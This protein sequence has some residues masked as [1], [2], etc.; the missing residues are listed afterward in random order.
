MANIFN[1]IKNYGKVKAE[2]A[3]EGAV[4]F[5]AS[6]DANGVSEAAIKQK[7]DEHNEM[8]KQLVDAQHSFK[9]E[10]Q[11]FDDIYQL[12]N[13]KVAAAERAQADLDKDP[14][15]ADAQTALV[16]LLDGIE[17]LAPRLEKE[18]REYE[19]AEQWMTELQRASDE[20]AQELLS[21]RDL[22]DQAKLDIKQAELDVK[23]QAKLKVQAEQLAGLRKSSNKFDVALTAI[24]K[25]AADKQKEAD[26]LRIATEQ[27]RKPTTKVS[28]ATSKY[29]DDVSD[30]T[31]QESL[32]DKLA[33]L[34]KIG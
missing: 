9:K 7:Q 6:I 15:N 10:K 30:S 16:E 17:K 20:V 13:K 32:Q 11:E 18:K 31:P 19:Q 8:V 23:Q 4:N 29:L 2:D 24:Q 28:T 14:S 25:Q 27:L 21:L 1:F 34:K 26:G 22:V 33:R 5:M 12:Y 3:S